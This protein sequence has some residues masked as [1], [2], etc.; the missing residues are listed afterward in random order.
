MFSPND[1]VLHPLHGAGVIEEITEQRVGGETRS[2]Y[3][4]N[5][6]SLKARLL[7]P[8]AGTA[9]G[10]RSLVSPDEA[11]QVIADFASVEVTE[12][13][14]WNKRYRENMDRLKSGKIEQAAA[15]YKSLL[16]RDRAKG[17]SSGE[18]KMFNTARQV[19]I[20]ELSAVLGME[21]EEIEAELQKNL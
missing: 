16:L 4:L 1:R 10:I 2:Y 11:R 18:H 9:A 14:N 12:S 15:V 5:I 8:V 21:N 20:S 17:L 6:P 7:I 13:P 19:L 3:V